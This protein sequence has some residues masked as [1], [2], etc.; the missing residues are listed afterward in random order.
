MSPVAVD[1]VNHTLPNATIHSSLAYTEGGLGEGQL[2]QST[3]EACTNLTFSV[4]SIRDHKKL[5]LYPDGPCKDAKLSQC[6][7]HIQ[8]FPCICPNGFIQNPTKES[9]CDCECDKALLPYI[10]NYTPQTQELVRESNIWITYVNS[11]ING[12]LL[13][14]HCP[15]D[16]CHPP[17]K[18][19]FINLNIENGSD[20]QCALER[21][22]LLCGTCR[23]GLSLSLGGSLCLSCPSYWPEMFIAILVAAF[24]SGIALIAL[25]LCLNLT[26]A[27]GSI[28]GIIFYANIVGANKSTFFPFT[29]PGAKFLSLFISWFN[30]AIGIDTCFFK[31]MD[32][33]WKTWLVLGFPTYTIIIVIAV[34]VISDRFVRFSEIIGRKNPVATLATLILLSYTTFLKTI[35]ETLSYSILNY[36]DGSKQTVWQTSMYPPWY[37]HP[38]AF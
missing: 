13:Q 33:Y 38:N 9:K 14:P 37:M 22:G 11:T 34:I 29:M 24:L 6:N 12:Y 26:V 10:S 8:F 27:V 23:Q 4:F 3:K 17:N 19:V 7:L 2:L 18:R 5:L 35:I 1:Q 16:Y 15:M 32:T 28:N 30:L 31:G 20:S 36:P 25:I 21:S